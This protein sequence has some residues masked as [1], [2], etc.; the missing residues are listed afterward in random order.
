MLGAI[1]RTGIVKIDS[2]K[3]AIMETFKNTVGEKNARAANEA[4]KKTK[5]K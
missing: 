3:K 5:K 2:I 4:Y 1:A